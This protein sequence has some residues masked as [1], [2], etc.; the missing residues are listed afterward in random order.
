MRPENTEIDLAPRAGFIRRFS[1]FMLFTTERDRYY[2][3][4]QKRSKTASK[5]DR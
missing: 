5:Y 4:V 3:L 2:T 1:G